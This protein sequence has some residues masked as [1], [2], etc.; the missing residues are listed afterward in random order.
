MIFIEA[1]GISIG[2]YPGNVYI[3]YIHVYV[4]HHGFDSSNVD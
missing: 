2:K 3:M 4:H 1:M